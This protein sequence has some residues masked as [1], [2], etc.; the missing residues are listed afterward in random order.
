[1]SWFKRRRPT[2]R[3]APPKPSGEDI[4]VAF[5]NGLSL[6]EW[7]ALP[8]LVKKDLREN[9]AWAGVGA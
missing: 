9:V 5:L 3:A 7:D 1:M 6:A 2:H 4:T 8:V